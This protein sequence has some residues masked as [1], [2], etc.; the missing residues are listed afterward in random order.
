VTD[1]QTTTDQP[2]VSLS[3]PAQIDA[4]QG[5]MNDA[6]TNLNGY[7]EALSGTDDAEQRLALADGARQWLAYTDTLAQQA[8]A[9]AGASNDMLVEMQQK[10]A[11]TTE[12]LELLV[13]A[14]ENVDDSDDRVAELIETV[15]EYVE[16]SAMLYADDMANEN[17]YE[18]VTENLMTHGGMS[19]SDAST[20]H[21]ALVD[22]KW[23]HLSNEMLDNLCAYLQ[24]LKKEE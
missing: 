21:S 19:S 5:E 18:Q 17:L 14:I 3:V 1:Q 4:L 2:V 13:D 10:L 15:T 11:A 23:A 12:E 20:I 24:S 9:I 7:L 8:T 22:G 16:E 6:L